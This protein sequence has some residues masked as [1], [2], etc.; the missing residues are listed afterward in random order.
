MLRLFRYLKPYWIQAVILVALI[1][2]QSFVT[3]RLPSLMANIINQGVT[4]NNPDIIYQTGAKMAVYTVIVV[5]LAIVANYFSATLSGKLARDIRR[6]IFQKVTSF[7]VADIDDFTTASLINRSTRDVS[8]VQGTITLCLSMAI[9]VPTMAIFAIVEAVRTAPNMTWIIALVVTVMVMTIAIIMATVIPKMNLW[10][11]LMDKITLLTRE[12]LTGL[13]VIRAFNNEGGEAKKFGR[14]NREITEVSFRIDAIM[15]LISPLLTLFFSGTSL[16]CIWIGISLMETDF[17]YL[18]NMMAF[19]QYAIQVVM[20]FLFLTMLFVMIPRSRIAAKR[21]NE[22]LDKKSEIKWRPKGEKNSGETAVEFRKVSFQYA[23]ADENVLTDVSFTAKAGETTA[24]IGS[25]GSG[26]TTLVSLVPRLYDATS[27][28]I[29]VN[30]KNLKDYGEKELMQKIGFVP[31][32]GRLFSGTVK[33]NLRFGRA[34]AT[35]E[36]IRKA[37]KVAQADEFIQKMEG[38]YDAK[39]SQGGTNVSGGQRQRLA[40]ARAIARKPEIYVFD[41]AFSALDLKTDAKLREELRKITKEAVVMIVAQRIGTIKNA[42]QIVV[43]DAGKVVGKGTHYH[44]LHSCRVYQEIAR[45]Q[46]SEEEF[47][48]E[49]QKSIPEEIGAR[50][51]LVGVTATKTVKRKEEK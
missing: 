48:Q 29:L 2:A 25:T 51:E 43:L 13:R 14:T 15:S 33:S 42:E 7:S 18:G 31:Q 23:G 6:D 3:L 38:G 21:I 5:I 37:A 50:A 1:G 27:G 26:K 16:L 10:Q 41:D 20:S 30:G 11:K 9:R 8:Q 12:N 46:M 36:E 24:F 4:D 32:R 17:S 39:I 34:T 44:L 35:D 28:E 45:S 40:I 49:L 47:R 19:M 22:V